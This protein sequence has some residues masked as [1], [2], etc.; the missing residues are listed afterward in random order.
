MTLDKFSDCTICGQYSKA[1]EFR[2][3]ANRNLPFT[4]TAHSRAGRV[5]KRW[6]GP[7]HSPVWEYLITSA[8]APAHPD[9]RH[10]YITDDESGDG[11]SLM[12]C[13][14]RC[15]ATTRTDS[16]WNPRERH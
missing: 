8:I 7:S 9:Q 6:P 14:V 16:S 3:A 10:A 5:P 2:G 13:I 11:K 12:D 15:G 4:L 1:I